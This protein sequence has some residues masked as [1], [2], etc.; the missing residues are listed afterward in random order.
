MG[1]YL[2]SL[3]SLKAKY[4]I[5]ITQATINNHELKIEKPYTLTDVL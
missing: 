1:D 4:P 3:R 5:K 2:L